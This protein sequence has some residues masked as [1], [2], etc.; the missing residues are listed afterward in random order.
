M[1]LHN[2]FAKCRIGGARLAVLALCAAVLF[3]L[4]LPPSLVA[5]GDTGLPSASQSADVQIRLTVTAPDEEPPPDNNGCTGPFRLLPLV[6]FSE[7]EPGKSLSQGLTLSSLSRSNLLFTAGVVSP[8]PNPDGTDAFSCA[9]WSRVS[10]AS[11]S[12]APLAS[13]ALALQYTIPRSLAAI[14]WFFGRLR[15]VA[16]DPQGRPAGSLERL[17]IVHN[18][19]ASAAGPQLSCLRFSCAPDRGRA[20]VLVTCINTGSQRLTLTAEGS[21]RDPR[22]QQPTRTIP[23][24]AT[25]NPVQSFC[26]MNLAGTLGLDTVADGEYELQVICRYEK[27]SLPLKAPVRVSTGPSGKT[28]AIVGPVV[29]TN[30]PDPS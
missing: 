10:P 14:P 24:S 29:A 28:I 1:N 18:K 12:L 22:G 23:L 13:R 4:L 30:V 15:I 16:T 25:P 20:K 17:V 19:K 6:V 8:I 7:G 27:G 2:L 3:S 9:A 11:F 5:L 26:E 21:L